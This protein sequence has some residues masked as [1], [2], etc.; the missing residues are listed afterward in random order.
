M[1]EIK[2]KKIFVLDTNVI[3][4]DYD[5]IEKFEEHDVRI[6]STV[7]QELDTFKKGNE[8]I[9]VN[10]REFHRKLKLLRETKV[11]KEFTSGKGNK[12]AIKFKKM[13]PALSHGGV[14]LGNGLG[15]IEIIRLPKELHPLV[16]SQ[17]F[18]STPDNWILSSVLEIEEQEIKGKRRRVILVTK[19][20]NLQAKADLLGIEVQDY[21]NDKVPNIEKLYMGRGELIH[22]GLSS[23][24]D[25]L[26]K[27]GK[28]PILGQ[29]YS[30]YIE[31]EELKP[32]KFF[33]IK[34]SNKNCLVR[35][36]GNMEYFHKV[37]KIKVAGI[38]PVNSEQVFSVSA[39]M[40]KDINLVTL[41][42]K[43]GTGKTLL[44]MATAIQQLKDNKYD[45]II[46]AAAMVPLSNR[47]IGALP[48]NEKEKVSPYMQGL[49]DNLSFI[50]SQMKGPKV[51]VVVETEEEA[52]TK[53]K[54]Q[55][56]APAV[57]EKIDYITSLLNDGKLRVQALASIRGRSLNNTLFIIDEAQNLTP[58]EV[59][60]II[61]R[62]GKNTKIVFCGDVQQIDSPYLD[63]RSNGLSHAIYRLAGKRI[64][65]HVTLVK[66][67]RSEL[68]ELAADLL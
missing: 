36:D 6:P 10:V 52:P 33:V 56:K 12:H 23:L 34:T 60:T 45:R 20:F 22:E 65:A 19:D 31:A 14:S 59:K 24:V 5:S 53:R 26:Y 51:D 25:V 17:F 15:N 13:V 18:H 58:H 39:L 7:I 2:E 28:A 37:E 46:V 9:N 29:E 43:A 27:S 61:T 48:G 1:S 67:E 57:V 41:M 11:E 55:K 49:F 47:D 40:N 64:V 32:N 35:V 50:Q 54:N 44:A 63:A 42:G 8:T 21:E 3:L 16:K 30:V 4:H 68:A 62:A 66:G 38:T